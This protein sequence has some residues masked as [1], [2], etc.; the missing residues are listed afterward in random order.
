MKTTQ[1]KI[2]T[3]YAE[4]ARQIVQDIAQGV[5]PAG[6]T[7]PNEHEF[8]AQ[9]GIS[10]GTVRAALRVVQELGLV[11][12]RK[13]AGTR[14]EPFQLAR[15]YSPS[16][17][18][19][20]ELTQ[21][22]ETAK[23]TVHSMKELIVDLDLSRRLGMQPGTRWLRVGTLRADP[24]TLG[25]SLC[26][27]DIYIEAQTGKQ[28]RDLIRRRDDLIC[29]LVQGATGRIIAEVQQRIRAIGVPKELAKRLGTEPDA[30]ALEITR[31]YLDQRGSLMEV[32][33]SVHPGDRFAYF[34]KLH[35]LKQP[36]TGRSGPNETATTKP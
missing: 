36:Q 32:V 20:E 11:S 3:R 1:T 5:Y 19:I 9:Y 4:L 25:R 13:R 24:N 8:A 6:S 18:S 22:G 12:R 17:S 29:N 16:I 30:H 10:R 14:V 21:Y 7:L 26:W 31:S 23:R 34:T 33:V 27:S 2:G 28:I 35:R 15:E